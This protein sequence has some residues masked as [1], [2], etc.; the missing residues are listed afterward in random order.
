[1]E[2]MMIYDYSEG[3]PKPTRICDAVYE[4][5]SVYLEIK[6]VKQA[7]IPLRDF[8]YQINGFLADI[9][10]KTKNKLKQNN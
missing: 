5:G 2:R 9:K 8:A 7:K 3:K 6:N 1:M 10:K 4:D